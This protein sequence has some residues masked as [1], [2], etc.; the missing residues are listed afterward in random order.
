[1]RK[2]GDL[3][4]RAIKETGGLTLVQS[5]EEAAFPDMPQNAIE[6]DG[7]IDFIGPINAIAEEI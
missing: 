5:P 3:G 6:Y 2:D 7:P 4:L 1:M